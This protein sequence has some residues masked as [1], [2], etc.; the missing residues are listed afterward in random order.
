MLGA[1]IGDIVG[2]RFEWNNNKNKEFEF[3]TYHCFFTDDSVMS[4]SIAKAILECQGD[5]KDL[6]KLAVKYMQEVG[7]PYPNCGYGGLFSE[8]MYS[9]QPK[10]Y[11]SFGNGAAMRVSACGFVATSLE[12][13]KYLSNKVTQVT[14]DHP[15]GPR[16]FFLQWI[17][18]INCQ[19]IKIFCWSYRKDLK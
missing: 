9:D 4:L 19:Q 16:L 18:W 7:Q 12:D 5:Y 13:A 3:L 8:W 2:S 17:L 1:I 15:E 10:P 6:D 14:H 11:K